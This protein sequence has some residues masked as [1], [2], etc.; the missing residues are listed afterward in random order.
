MKID[1]DFM[2]DFL[3]LFQKVI[4]R[5]VKLVK[6][7][8]EVRE[9]CGVDVAYWGETG[10]AV[11]VCEGEKRLINTAK[12]KVTF[13]YIPG[14]LFMREAPIMIKALRDISRPLTS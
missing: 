12:G 10:V 6:L 5:E 11:A 7:N 2:V 13:P 14:L 3:K 8:K 9:L 1:Q 4:S